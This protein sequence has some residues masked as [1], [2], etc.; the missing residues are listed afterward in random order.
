[1]KKIVTLVLSTVMALSFSATAFAAEINQDSNPKSVKATI[2]T[3]VAPTYTVSI[4]ANITVGFNDESTDFGAIKVT[5]ARIDPDK[6]IKVSIATDGE[7]N[8]KK[9]AEKV[10][11]YTVNE[12]GGNKFTSA[13]YTALG[14]QTNLTVNIAKDDWNKAY[15]GEYEDTVTFNIDY[16]AK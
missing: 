16:I 7:L 1:M 9:D 2:S 12:K 4:P 10:I 14:E 15:A 11:P 3:M 6:C 8:N 5:S 13:T